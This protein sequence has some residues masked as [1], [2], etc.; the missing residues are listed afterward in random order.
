MAAGLAGG[1]PLDPGIAQAPRARGAAH[2]IPGSTSSAASE[3]ES[4]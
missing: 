2:K 4:S 1:R 3:N